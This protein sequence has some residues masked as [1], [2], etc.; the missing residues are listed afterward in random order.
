MPIISIEGMDGA[1]KTT[2]ISNLRTTGQSFWILSRAKRVKDVEELRSS[3]IWMNC[4]PHNRILILDR[5]PLISESVYGEILRGENLQDQLDPSFLEYY[6]RCI[7]RVVYCR[8]LTATIRK[9]IQN[10]GQMKG[11]SENI[12]RLIIRYDNVIAGLKMSGIDV[13]EY[14]YE[15]L[16]HA[17]L[18]GKI[19]TIGSK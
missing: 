16:N 11:V 5:H 1:G 14:D 17:D 12:H 10:S 15:D 13:I 7:T 9:N 6:Y 4:L 3:L 19:L 18:F 8:P 2:L